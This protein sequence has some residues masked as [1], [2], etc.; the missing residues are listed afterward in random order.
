MDCLAGRG[1]LVVADQAVG[2]FG[3]VDGL[4]VVAGPRAVRDRVTVTV[5]YV[6]R[7]APAVRRALAAARALPC[8]CGEEVDF[9][10]GVA[11]E[12]DFHCSGLS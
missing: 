7:H 5:V 8:G 12:D 6:A 11:G 3:L 4:A 2:P 9:C 10:E 1:C